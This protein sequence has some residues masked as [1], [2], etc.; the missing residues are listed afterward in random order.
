MDKSLSRCYRLGGEWINIFLTH[1]VQMY[2]KPYNGC[3]IQGSCCGK[4]MMILKLKLVK[5]KTVDEADIASNLT[6]PYE[7]LKHVTT[8]LK[9]L[10]QP[11]VKRI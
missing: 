5:G 7:Y 3:K 2:C 9:Y 1:Y 10:V 6:A 11:W 4:S 8:V